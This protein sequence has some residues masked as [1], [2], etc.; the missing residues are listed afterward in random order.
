PLARIHPSLLAEPNGD[1]ILHANGIEAPG[2]PKTVALTTVLKR[3]EA[4]IKEFPNVNAEAGRLINLR[5]G[6]LHSSATVLADIEKSDWLGAY[7]EVVKVIVEHL[8]I[9]ISDVLP[10]SV[11]KQAAE[12][13]AASRTKIKFEVARRVEQSST[14]LSLLTAS[15]VKARLTT[16]YPRAVAFP[17][18]TYIPCP[19]CSNRAILETAVVRVTRD[20]YNEGD[21]VIERDFVS[22]AKNF[23]CVVCELELHGVH[24]VEAAGLE[25]EYVET[26]VESLADR[27]SEQFYEPDYGND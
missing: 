23:L 20:R 6:E 1:S 13:A 3:L 10:E 21:D 22:I 4:I 2:D 26:I 27:Y 8:D 14:M 25:S 9:P 18:S 11:V 7:Y 17:E 16:L 24:E 12:Y 15:D 19:V 5:N